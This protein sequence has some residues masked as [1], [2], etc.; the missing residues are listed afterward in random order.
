MK[1]YSDKHLNDKQKQIQ[2]LALENF[3]AY[4]SLVAPYLQLGDCHREM[5]DVLS[6]ER[7]THVLILYPRAH[8]KSKMMALY[9]AWR[10]TV[11]P[12]LTI[13]Y[14]SAT[15]TLAQAQLFDIKR[16]LD[17]PTSAKYFPELLQG[18]TDGMREKWSQESINLE[19]PLRKKKGIRDNTIATAG[20]GKNI[21]GLHFDM[22]ILDDI[23]APDTDVDPWT[24]SGRRK[25]ETWASLAASILNAGGQI[26]AVGTRYHPK[27]IYGSLKS[28]N[29]PVMDENLNVINEV[30]MYRVME[31]VVETDGEFLWPR[32]QASDGKFYGFDPEQLAKIKSQ[33][34][35][36]SQFF[37]QYYN[38]PSDP[39][40]KKIDSDN[41]Q[42]FD[43]G[44]L[45]C[46]ANTWFIS[47]KKLEI[48]AAMDIAASIAKT[49][50]Y[51]TLVVVGV[52]E[53]GYRYVLDIQRYKTDQISKMTE[54][55]FSA[56]AK[57]RF[58]VFRIE[59]NSSQGLV[60]KQLQK[61]LRAK[62][63]IFKW[64]MQHSKKEKHMRI[65]SILEPMYAQK[66]IWHYK[67]GNTEFLEDE[68]IATKTAHDDV[69]DALAACM[70]VV[71]MKLV[72]RRRKS[73]DSKVIYNKR[74]G[75]VAS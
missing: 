29:V 49:A 19:H 40:N 9:A 38:D 16:L 67:G 17:N 18:K 75:G 32:R 12:A 7:D 71:P 44:N 10:V 52:D 4:I 36:Q 15:A 45:Q 74:F 72:A 14:A 39:E 27:D 31:N 63:A 22:L 37:A 35:D 54:M 43:K 2:Q 23:T 42:Y 28:I 46:I 47:G 59:T 60:A 25:C 13:L 51:T 55:L 41:F 56:Y 69:S 8:L 62:N 6:D 68:L 58:K 70:E 11:D 34:I 21:T 57:W 33:Y 5:A 53:D 64:D 30:P 1:L 66:M 20:A 26:K 65:M 24:Q 3:N 50:D 73:K 48:Y 61:D